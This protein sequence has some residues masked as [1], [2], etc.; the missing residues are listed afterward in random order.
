[1]LDL[2]RGGLLLVPP[3]GCRAGLGARISLDIRAVGRVPVAVVGASPRG[4]HCAAAGR[5]AEARLRDALV[6]IEEEHRPL[7]AA[8]RGGAAAVALAME[9]ALA[10][11]R[12]DREALFDGDYRPVAGIDPPHYLTVA[13]PVLED[14]L[15]PI[16][17]PRLLADARAAFCIAVD[18]NG[19]APV[20]NRSQAQDPR[21]GDPDWNALHARHRRLH[22]D[23]VGL[24]AARST[25][26]FLV[27]SSP[28]G[29]HGRTAPLREVAAPI[30]VHG[31][32]WGALRIAYRL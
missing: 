18:R 23:P 4:L 21:A 12:L 14:I 10:A 5:E 6:A 26:P 1:M 17:E 13:L 3:E 11:G 16:L 27:Q 24:A 19:Y 29:S 25:R 7:I 20:H 28:P 30:R 15:P 9:Q 32:H 2:G 31:R 8:A 22:D